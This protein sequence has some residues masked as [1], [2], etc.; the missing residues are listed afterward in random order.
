M[1]R[2]GD[3]ILLGLSGG[4]DS[5]SLLHTPAPSAAEGPVKF[6]LLAC[7][8][9]PAVRP[10]RPVAAEALPGRARRA[11]LSRIAAD[12]GRGAEDPDQ[13]FRFLLR[14]LLA[15]A[16]RHSLPRRP[17]AELQRSSPWPTIWDD[18]AETLMMS[19]LFGGK[20]RTMSPHYLNDAG[21]PAH[22]PATFAYARERQTRR[23]RT[24]DSG[25][26]R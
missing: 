20:L 17:R 7:T 5:L 3:C 22:H 10:V 2:A 16:A 6:E 25:L 9:R 14:L 8:G 13:G 4:K 18:L 11:L 21:R 12:H 26:T 15:H 24:D 23:L 1:I 19:M